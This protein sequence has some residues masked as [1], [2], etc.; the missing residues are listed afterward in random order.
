[1]ISFLQQHYRR[2][3]DNG[4]DHAQYCVV[5]DLTDE[6]AAELADWYGKLEEQDERDQQD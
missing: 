5:N 3:R 4:L 2:A 6:T 1:M